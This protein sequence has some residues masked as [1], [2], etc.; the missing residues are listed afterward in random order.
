[1][2]TVSGTQEEYHVDV[3]SGNHPLYKGAQSVAAVDDGPLSRFNAKYEGMDDL[4]AVPDLGTKEVE[5]LEGLKKER[6]KKPKP[7]PPAEE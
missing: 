3:W 4:L 5:G 7:T 2:L 1:M 6:K